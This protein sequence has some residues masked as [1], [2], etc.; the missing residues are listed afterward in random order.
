[1]VDSVPHEPKVS[2]SIPNRVISKT[3]LKC[4]QILSCLVLRIIIWID[5]T[6]LSS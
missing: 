4:N 3:V 2:G 1:V 6:S 5:L